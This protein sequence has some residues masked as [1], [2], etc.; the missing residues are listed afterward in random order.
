MNDSEYEL[1]PEELQKTLIGFLGHTYKEV[2]QF[3][4]RLI[5]ANQTLSPK[6]QELEN[7]AQRVMVEAVKPNFQSMN[8]IPINGP[9]QH[10]LHQQPQHQQ[11]PPQHQQIIQNT[12]PVDANQMEFAFDNSITAISI[13]NRLDDIENRLKRLDSAVSKMLVLLQTNDTENTK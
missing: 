13:N 6:K 7:I 5:S 1:T 11:Y 10:Q 9:V 12:P 4:S 3:D 2:S 8:N